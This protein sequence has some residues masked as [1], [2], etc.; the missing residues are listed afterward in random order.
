MLIM[1]SFKK[2][3]IAEQFQGN[4]LKMQVNHFHPS[5]HVWNDRPLFA[6]KNYRVKGSIFQQ[7]STFNHL[8]LLKTKS[9]KIIP[10]VAGYLF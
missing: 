9:R 2:S 10:N 3:L 5:F 8:Y 7:N 1:P 6:E 4:Y